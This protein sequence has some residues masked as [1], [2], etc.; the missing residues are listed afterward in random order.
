MKR[1]LNRDQEYIGQLKSFIAKENELPY[2]EIVNELLRWCVP[3][4]QFAQ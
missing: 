4:G 2:I 1:Y 3:S